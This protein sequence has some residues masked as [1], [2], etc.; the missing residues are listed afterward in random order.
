MIDAGEVGALFRIV[1]EAS[2]VLRRLMEQF[3]ALQEVIDRTK[4]ALRELTMPPGVSASIARINRSLTTATDAAGRLEKSFGAIDGASQVAADAA[5]GNF[6][7][8]DGSITGTT[9]LIG[10][11][12]A[13][14][15]AV[16]AQSAEI[17]R[18]QSF[19]RPRATSGAANLR[20][21]GGGHLGGGPGGPHVTTAGIP[22]PGGAHVSGGHGLGM[23]AAGALAYGVYLEAEIEDIAAR[24]LLTGQIKVDSGMT[25]GAAFKSVRDLIQRVSAQTGFAPK[26]VGE[27]ILTTERQFGGLSFK[28]RLGIEE[29]LIPFAAAEARMKEA[30][31]PQ[32]FEAMVGLAHMTGT[33]DPKQLPELMRQFSYASMITPVPIEQFQRAI[34]Y[35]LPMLHAG[36][37]MDPSSIMFLTAM[38]QTAGITNTKSGTWLR[39]FFENAEPKLGDHLSKQAKTHNEALQKMGLLDAHDNVTWQVKDAQGKTDWDKSIVKMSEAINH[40]TQ[41]TDPATRLSTIRSA[42]GERGGGFA[43]LMNLSQFIEQFPVLQAKM[44]AFSGGDNVLTALQEASPVQQA[45]TAWA[46]TENVLM[47][48]GQSVLPPL[49]GALR[50]FDA[51]LKMLHGTLST[52]TGDAGANNIM[53][54]GF[55]GAAGAYFTRKLWWPKSGAAT[56]P[57]AA[58]PAADAG[59]EAGWLAG[60]MRWLKN[61]MPAS[62]PS[63]I[64]Q[65]TDF[66][67]DPRYKAS[68]GGWEGVKTYFKTLFDPK[69]YAP[70]LDPKTYGFSASQ[71][72]ATSVAAAVPAMPTVARLALPPEVEALV[73]QSYKDRHNPAL[74]GF[75]TDP[76]AARGRALGGLPKSI[77]DA[78][79]TLPGQVQPAISNTFSQIGGALSSAISGMV[80][81]ASAAAAAIPGAASKAVTVHTAVNLDGRKMAQVVTTHQMADSRTA[82][83]TARYDGSSGA[84]PTDYA[85]T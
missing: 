58:A 42:F 49:T 1:D 23:A 74:H 21:G 7:R 71:A 51:G 26:E 85:Y 33:Y 61:A 8:I 40:F 67:N 12:S 44:K 53:G 57:S 25:S 27:A 83:S 36:L 3:D 63:L 46:D 70:L 84:T 56:A 4:L 15:K 32:A 5:I 31:L 18:A 73:A 50:G 60:G 29:T 77:T 68:P 39:S 82:S 81:Q 52:I 11:M 65:M 48:I 24:A 6:S 62:L 28:D 72:A 75:G 16:S 47:D 20:Y 2:P 80:A 43:S 69:T 10:D 76:E 41:A 45:R 59:A 13:E 66:S 64:D 35:S 78:L 34:G 19:V 14:L 79:N 55:L 37:D 9:K 22:L 54:A 30:T 38:T 17:S